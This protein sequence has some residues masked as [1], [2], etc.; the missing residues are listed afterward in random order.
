MKAECEWDGW[1]DENGANP[2]E[3]LEEIGNFLKFEPILIDSI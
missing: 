1:G 3:V 2:N